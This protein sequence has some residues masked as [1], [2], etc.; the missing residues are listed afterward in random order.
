MT[1]SGSAV[2]MDSVHPSSARQGSA[3]D[4]RERQVEAIRH[5]NRFY[6]PRIG[7]LEEGYLNSGLSVAEAR[8]IYEIAH[9]QPVT[10]AELC[11]ALQIDQG[12][13]SRILRAFSAR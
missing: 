13:L 10:A 12:F 6:T 5:F 7:I 8:V 2:S 11:R 3:Q 1:T 9:R 4:L